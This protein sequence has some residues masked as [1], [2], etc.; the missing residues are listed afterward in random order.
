MDWTDERAEQLK[1][2]RDLLVTMSGLNR[3]SL[4]LENVQFCIKTAQR[5]QESHDLH[6]SFVSYLEKICVAEREKEREKG[7]P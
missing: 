7:H 6:P 4:F 1:E 5:L 2:L 3:G